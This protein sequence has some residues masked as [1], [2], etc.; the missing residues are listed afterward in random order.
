MCPD[1]QILSVYVDGELPSPWKEKMEAHLAVCPRCQKQ[2]ADFKSV[3]LSKVDGAAGNTVIVEASLRATQDRL[4]QKFERME[5]THW[6]YVKQRGV[7]QRS[8]AVPLPAVAAAAAALIAACTFIITRPAV[9]APPSH[10]SVAGAHSQ[11]TVVPISD[12]KEVLQYLGK[13]DAGDIVIIK[14]PESKS[15]SSSGE[16]ALIKAADYSRSRSAP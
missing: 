3:S 5:T 4:W 7:W 12:M 16:P 6:R 9:A 2:L 1:Y 13:E 15:F 10:E 14:L 8:V 11:S